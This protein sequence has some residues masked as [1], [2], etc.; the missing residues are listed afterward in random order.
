MNADVAAHPPAVPKMGPDPVLI[1][2]KEVDV[3]YEILRAVSSALSMLNIDYIV[4]G[5]SLLG[6]VRQHSILFCDDDIDIAIIEN[7]SSRSCY[8]LASAHLQELIGAEFVY[9]VRPWEGGDRVR[10]RS[11]ATVFLDLFTIRR[12]DTIDQLKELIGTKKNGKPQSDEYIQDIVQKLEASAFSQNEQTPLCP[13]WHF[14]TRKA[15]EMWPKEVYRHHEMF[16]LTSDLKFGPL[17]RINGPK[18]PVLLLKRAFGLDCFE[19]YFQSG[20][21]KN[22]KCLSSSAPTAT[23]DGLNL[24]PLVLSGGTWEGEQKTVLEEEHYLPMQPTSRAKRR[25]TLHDK[26]HLASFL[27]V[28]SEREAQWI[29]HWSNV[30]LRRSAAFVAGMGIAQIKTTVYMD[31]VFDLFHVGH[32]EAIKRCS[33]LGDRVIIGVTGDVDAADYKRPP[34]ISQANRV[35]VVAAIQNVAYV[36]CPCPLIVTEEFMEQ[37]KIDLV[38]HGFAN[39]ADA[40]RQEEFFAIP[41][42]MGKFMRIPYYEGLSTTDIIKKIKD[43]SNLDSS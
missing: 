8:Q 17:V 1:S 23:S 3:L 11:T 22:A 33:E 21:H 26:D 15:V 18:T 12:F 28:Q 9:Q 38:V 7:D 25:P 6:A 41:V 40:R 20:S 42:R 39:D 32:L 19:V 13:F 29:G 4:T 10:S 35:A 43:L 31:G 14:D 30:S 27:S 36:V 34:V 24:P 16:P 5:G 37:H 2:R